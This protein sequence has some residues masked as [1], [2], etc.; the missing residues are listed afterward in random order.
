MDEN[1]KSGTWR[2]ILV[3]AIA[4]LLGA[5]GIISSLLMLETRVQ[6][7]QVVKELN[8]QEVYLRLSNAQEND[9][10][11]FS[12]NGS[13]LLG[14]KSAPLTIYFIGDF[15]CPFCRKFFEESVP[16]LEKDFLDKGLASI[17]Y[18]NFPLPSHTSAQSAALAGLA[19]NKQ[20]AFWIMAK[21][22]F[23]GQ[24]GLGVESY[25]NIASHAGLD[26]DKFKTDFESPAEQMRLNQEI[27][28][29]QNAG[30]HATPTLVIEGK[31]FVGLMPYDELKQIL[32]LLL[33]AKKAGSSLI[34]AHKEDP[35]VGPHCQS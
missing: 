13:P 34:G 15:E 20:G 35:F 6:L 22:L 25:L 30:I 16:N 33:D 21:H 10:A 17:A 26:V 24:E 27:I 1:K 7:S 3:G 29:E 4:L 28:E 9:S 14:Q 32:E 5:Y 19:A 11:I 23:D 31:V 8:R 18:K 2:K 12:V